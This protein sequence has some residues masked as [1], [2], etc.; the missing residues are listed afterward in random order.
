M[1][2]CVICGRVIHMYCI[3]ADG[4]NYAHRR[5][6]KKALLKMGFAGVKKVSRIDWE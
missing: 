6:Y 2:R 1:A 4:T 3:T 5:C